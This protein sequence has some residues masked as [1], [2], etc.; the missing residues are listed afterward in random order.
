MSP[1]HDELC[2]LLVTQQVGHMLNLINVFYF[3]N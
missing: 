3:I 1:G 2:A